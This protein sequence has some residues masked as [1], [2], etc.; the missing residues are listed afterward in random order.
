VLLFAGVA[1]VWAPALANGFVWDDAGNLVRS[2]RLR[3]WTALYEVFLHDAMW[4]AGR[5]GVGT[6]R[7][8]ALASMALD[9]QLFGHVA[10]GYHLGSVLLHCAAAV[11]VF[12]A[13]AR[14]VPSRAAFWLAA[15][16][17]V[18]PTTVEVAA[19]INGRSESLALLFGAG[20]LWVLCVPKP[21][22]RRLVAGG[23]LLL[24]AMLG[25]ETGAI[26]APGAVLCVALVQRREGHASG[27]L[28]WPTALV[29]SGAVA[30]YFAIRALVLD[31]ASVGPSLEVFAVLPAVWFRATQAVVAPL[32]RGLH[33]LTPWLSGLDG[34]ALLGYTLATLA[35]AGLA[36]VAWRRGERR[37]ALG[38]LWW[39]GSLVPVALLAVSAWPGFYRWLYI[40]LPGLLLALYVSL[41]D[42]PAARWICAVALVAGVVRTELTIPVWRTSG[43]LFVA[44]VES[45]PDDPYGYHG[46]G[47][48][49]RDIGDFQAAE[50]VLREGLA[51][52]P[53]R[54]EMYVALSSVLAAQGRCAE[55]VE[56]VRGRGARIPPELRAQIAAC[57]VSPRGP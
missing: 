48:Y 18:H 26:F 20:A 43:T 27:P 34:P 11:A 44:M 51:L 4:S 24:L 37:P 53:R 21:R 17:A 16:W 15:V 42:R 13:L 38:L 9:H 57:R 2:T 49:L 32:E 7:P 5:E 1:A 6:Y 50:R 23:A 14:L 35:A 39:C 25:K 28:H 40:G 56:A 33:V 22:R 30:V 41:G 45:Q 54:L 55:A 31:A 19:W 12:G 29:A 36:V 8:L 52:G 10:W 3:A 46:L 47:E